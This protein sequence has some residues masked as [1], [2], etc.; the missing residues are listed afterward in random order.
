[1]THIPNILGHVKDAELRKVLEEQSGKPLPHIGQ[2]Y[3]SADIVMPWLEG[4][5]FSDFSYFDMKDFN[6]NEPILISHFVLNPVFN[7]PDFLPPEGSDSDWD[8]AELTQQGEKILEQMRAAG[9][10]V[11]MGYHLVNDK[12]GND[13]ATQM[14]LFVPNTR[15]EKLNWGSG[16]VY[17]QTN[18]EQVAAFI[19]HLSELGYIDLPMQQ[20]EIQ[21]AYGA[22]AMYWLSKEQ[23]FP[24]PV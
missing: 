16:K 11:G 3:A 7:F 12:H 15:P 20:D 21:A 4:S 13:I 23:P 5:M 6:E 24:A 19:F 2:S 22:Q 14:F 8:P 18:V 9:C 17:L 10:Y 1:M